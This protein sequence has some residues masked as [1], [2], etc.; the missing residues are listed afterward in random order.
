MDITLIQKQYHSHNV[1]WLQLL[2]AINQ[3]IK[4]LLFLVLLTLVWVCDCCHYSFVIA[5]CVA[6]M[7]LQLIMP[8]WSYTQM[9]MNAHVAPIQIRIKSKRLDRTKFCSHLQ[10]P[11]VMTICGWAIVA[12]NHRRSNWL[13]NYNESQQRKTI[14]QNHNV[15]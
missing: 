5:D 1:V 12:S 3:S 6:I 2:F 10:T 8:R 4:L 13:C 14:V 11:I 9:I 15:S 7:W